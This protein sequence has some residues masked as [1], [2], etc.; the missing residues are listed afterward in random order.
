MKKIGFIGFGNMGS[1]LVKGIINSDMMGQVIESPSDISVYDKDEAKMQ[2]AKN[3]GLTTYPSAEDLVMNS[4]IIFLAVK[5][6]DLKDSTSSIKKAFEIFPDSKSSKVIVSILAGIK[7]SK[8]YECLGD[9]SV[10]IVRVMPNTPALVGE[11]CFG[12]FFT[13]KVPEEDRKIILSI[14]ENLGTY[15]IV[16]NETLMDVITGLSGS[17]PAYV[18]LVIQALADGGVRMGLDRRTATVLAAQTVLGAAKMVM[19]NLG[20]IHPEELKDMV[21]SPGGTTAEGIT[22]LEEN[23]VRYAFIKAVEEATK[24]SQKLSS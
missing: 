11:G 23:R 16:E 19:E 20:K 7:I 10:P 24:K 9:D 2:I 17:G 5:P 1:A 22:I 4:D 14:F 3:D 8:I 12:I 18:F 6:K 15:V 21:M 13:E